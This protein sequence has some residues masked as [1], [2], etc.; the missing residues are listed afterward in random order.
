MKS[1]QLKYQESVERNL[2]NLKLRDFKTESELL[3][4]DI[5]SIRKLNNSFLNVII[6]CIDAKVNI[7]QINSENYR[8]KFDIS[9]Q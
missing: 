6:H 7:R 3:F 5:S 2:K 1:K 8:Y 9:I 4:D